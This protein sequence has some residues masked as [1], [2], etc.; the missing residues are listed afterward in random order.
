[1]C[2]IAGYIGKKKITSQSI[3][4]LSKAMHNRGPDNFSYSYIKIKKDLNLYFFHSRL[5]IIDLNS[6]ANQPYKFKNYTLIYNGEIYN[7]LELRKKLMNLGYKFKTNSDTEVLIK[8]FAHYKN[9]MF[10]FLQGMWSFAIWDDKTKQLILSRD[11]FGEK[12]LFYSKINDE[13]FFSSEINYINILRNKKGEIDN[14][15]FKRNFYYGYKAP[16]L[17]SNLTQFKDIKFLN[18]SNNLYINKDLNVVKKKYWD[19]KYKLNKKISYEQFKK[20]LRKI[21]I[22]TLEKTMRSDVDCV[23]SLSGGIDSSI[24]VNIATKILKRKIKCYTIYDENP[25]YDESRNVEDN[26]KENPLID[27]KYIYP[28]KLNLNYFKKM[29]SFNLNSFYT[30]TAC[31]QNYFYQRIS[32][33][34]HKVCITGLGADEIFTGYYHHY[35]YYFSML[36]NLKSNKNYKIW[37]KTTK[38]FLKN[39]LVKNVKN[40]DKISVFRSDND[41]DIQNCLSFKVD[42]KNY[43]FNDFN[44]KNTLR[45]KL[46]FE[47]FYETLPVLLYHEDITSMSHSV[48]SRCPFLN[49]KIVE[50][51]SQVDNKYLIKNGY[52]KYI[53]RDTFKDL[54]PENLVFDINKRGFNYSFSNFYNYKKI[55][56]ILFKK[57]TIIKNFIFS[58]KLIKLIN[59]KNYSGLHKFI[60]SLL[61]LKLL[62][63]LN[64]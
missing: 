19:V 43:E 42:N 59:F 52:L 24:L 3:S 41:K 44:K 13:L 29:I 34:G 12:P 64:K 5:S 7:Y 18:S 46:N 8:M 14:E 16:F 56:S 60:F 54:L 28:K 11:R 61:N 51:V 33:D 1:M 36:K 49:H 22:S 26:I 63:N 37:E 57:D 30:I 23:F 45:S 27:H 55:T 6:K 15:F 32:K 47:Q 48:E 53:L 31:V 50:L 58:K 62:N 21:V 39:P 2:G 40:L 10:K 38:K 20:K 35:L 17:N 4:Y 9:D 25:M